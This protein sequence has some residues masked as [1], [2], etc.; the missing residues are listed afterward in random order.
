VVLFAQEQPMPRI[1][2]HLAR[3]A[4]AG[5]IG[6]TDELDALLHCL[7]PGG[8][9]VV[10]LHGGSNLVDV[11]VRSLRKKLARQAAMI[12]TVHGTGYRLRRN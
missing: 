8:P 1:R 6:R 10:H 12:E 5:L 2:D 7:Q 3:Q 11:V 9:R 4:V